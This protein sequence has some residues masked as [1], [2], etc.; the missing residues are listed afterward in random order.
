LGQNLNRGLGEMVAELANKQKYIFIT[1]IPLSNMPTFFGVQNIG[2][3]SCPYRISNSAELV[4]S[5]RELGY[6]LIDEWQC[7]ESAC[8]VARHK[9]RT[10]RFYSGFY[11]TREP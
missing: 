5:V 7:H 6:K 9:S 2:D 10:V 11:F 1:R 3:S 8:F 4:E